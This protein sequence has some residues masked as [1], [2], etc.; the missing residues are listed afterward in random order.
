MQTNQSCKELC[1][2]EI[3]AMNFLL[4]SCRRCAF[5]EVLADSNCKWIRMNTRRLDIDVAVALTRFCGILETRL[6]QS[7]SLV[8]TAM[9]HSVG[10]LTSSEDRLP[11]GCTCVLCCVA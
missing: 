9:V 8:S 1:Y 11:I 6:I 7:V 3:H 4:K 5:F 10:L 2:R